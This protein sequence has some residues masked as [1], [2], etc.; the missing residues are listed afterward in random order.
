LLYNNSMKL[1]RA[2]I[3]DNCFLVILVASLFLVACARDNKPAAVGSATGLSA[4]KLT[5]PEEEVT[6]PSAEINATT[7]TNGEHMELRVKELHIGTGFDLA[8]RKIEGETDKLPP[9]TVKLW[10]YSIITGASNETF[11][12]HVYYCKGRQVADVKLDVKYPIFSTWSSKTI[13]PE[14]KGAW[15]I[16]VIDFDGCVIGEKGFTLE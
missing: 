7:V 6:R 10:C 3:A 4:E 16:K 14:W 11:V 1:Y 12:R 15:K 8:T 2:N 5:T 9:T 13:L